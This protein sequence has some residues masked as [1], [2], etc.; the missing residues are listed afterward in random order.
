MT[1]YLARGAVSILLILL[2]VFKFLSLNALSTA[3]NEFKL[4]NLNSVSFLKS[5]TVFFTSYIENDGDREFI[6]LSDGSEVIIIY[7]D[8][9]NEPFSLYLNFD[10]SPCKSFIPLRINFDNQIFMIYSP[11]K[12]KL[13]LGSKLVESI[14][15]TPLE[16]SVPC[17]VKGDS[18]DFFGKIYI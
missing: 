2:I 10:F 4:D 12:F 11:G 6:W 9:L 3:Q 17:F 7:N 8:H 18:R 14:S 15:I 1:L 16:D 5:Q 13:D